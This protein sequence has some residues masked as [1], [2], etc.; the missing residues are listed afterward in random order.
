MRN[1]KYHFEKLGREAYVPDGPISPIEGP[2]LDID[3][4]ADPNASFNDK[5]LIINAKVE[6][7]KRKT[8]IEINTYVL[9]NVFSETILLFTLIGLIALGCITRLNS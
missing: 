1:D 7:T 2:T 5:P 8:N 4:N 3:A 9:D 6:I